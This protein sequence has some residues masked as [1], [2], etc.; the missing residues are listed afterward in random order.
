L[1]NIEKEKMATVLEHCN[2]RFSSVLSTAAF[3]SHHT[4]GHNPE[5]VGLSNVAIPSHCP[6]FFRRALLDDLERPLNSATN[7]TKR[8]T[9]DRD[10]RALFAICRLMEPRIKFRMSH[11]QSFW[12]VVVVVVVVVVDVGRLLQKPAELRG[13]SSRSHASFHMPWEPAENSSGDIRLT[14]ALLGPLLGNKPRLTKTLLT[15]PPFRF[16]W[17][18]VAKVRKI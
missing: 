9:R 14:R 18:I 11:L 5:E 1:E 8:C 4:L 17:D 3:V 2:N 12:H 13:L 16:I 15:R 6:N 7:D 10:A